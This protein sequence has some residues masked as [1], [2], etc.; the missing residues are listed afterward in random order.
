MSNE[1]YVKVEAEATIN[2]NGQIVGWKD[3]E[4]GPDSEYWSEAS[5]SSIEENNKERARLFT[6]LGGAALRIGPIEPNKYYPYSE[7]TSNLQ[8]GDKVRGFKF[9]PYDR[10]SRGKKMRHGSI[11]GHWTTEKQPVT[12]ENSAIMA[13]VDTA[14]STKKLSES[15]KM[16][17]CPRIGMM[18]I[19]KIKSQA[20]C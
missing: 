1:G 17:F 9:V 19:L 2:K 11:S 12:K 15:A 7:D 13:K 6:K 18:K 3:L 20:G 10:L 4:S 14:K 5:L 8:K 16:L